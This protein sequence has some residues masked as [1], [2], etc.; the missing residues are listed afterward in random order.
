MTSLRERAGLPLYPDLRC[1]TLKTMRSM[2]LPTSNADI[3]GAVASALSLTTEQRAALSRNGRQTELAYRVAWVRTYLRWIGAI[4][5]AGRTLWTTTVSG[6]AMDC[7]EL[8]SRYKSFRRTQR[9]DGPPEP[10]NGYGDNGGGGDPDPP[11]ELN[12]KGM[13]LE[14]LMETS[15]QAFE[16]LAGALL[17]A[18]GFDDVE[19]TGRSGDGGIDGLGVYRPAGLISFHTAFQCKRYQGSVGASTV[20]DFRGSFIGRSERGIIITT[21][22]FTRDARAEAGRAG[23]NPV[24]LIDGDD[25]CELLMEHRLGVRVTERT[26]EDIAVDTT[27]FDQFEVSK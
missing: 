27:Y 6:Q 13:L 8:E 23:A 21:G 4:D 25:L 17:Q 15:P 7:E 26:V 18:A 2:T 19:V 10:A 1:I 16:H 22:T 11:I 24:D 3:D 14:R 5:S 9:Q 12:W 20:R